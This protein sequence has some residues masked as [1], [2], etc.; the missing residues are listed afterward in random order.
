MDAGRATF[1]AGLG[2]VLRSYR[3]DVGTCTL[4]AGD[5]HHFATNVHYAWPHDTLPVLYVA[6]SSRENRE[7]VGADHAVHALG[8]DARTGALTPIGRS[9]VLPNRAV[10]VTCDAT[11]RHLLAAFNDPAGLAVVGIN[12]D[13]SLGEV[14]EQRDGLDVGIFPHQIRV[15]PDNRR[16]ILVT[17]GN[18]ASRGWWAH[19]SRQKDP[20]A[21]KVFEY[22]DGVLGDAAS[23]TIGDGF[24]F[25][26]RHLDFHPSSPWVYVCLETQNDVVVFRRDQDGGLSSPPLQQ[27]STLL[28]PDEVYVRQGAGTVHVHP[29]G[30][31]VYVANRGHVPVPQ[32]DGRALL[33]GVDNTL[34]VYAIDPDDGRLEEIQRI[35]AGGICPRTFSLDPTGR[36]LVAANAETHLVK[37]GADAR[38]VPANLSTFEVLDD[39]RLAFRRRYEVEL[40][41]GKQI[42]WSGAVPY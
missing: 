15:T 2:T 11:S 10:H 31:V 41:P 26:P 5:E 34:V 38:Q 24:G 33:T 7:N 3:M 23:I 40:A 19:K 32:R 30:H 14:V 27:M 9:V 42:I 6:T 8:V 37:D 21:L 4:E 36:M 22:D 39:G 28:D 16:C 17:R 29:Q 35:D 1:Y 13:G 18:P 12:D 25:G 20:G